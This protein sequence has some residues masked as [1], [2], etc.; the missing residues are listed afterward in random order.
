[1]ARL[2]PTDFRARTGRQTGQAKNGR[3]NSAEMGSAVNN[4]AFP[5]FGDLW[6]DLLR[7]WEDTGNSLG[8]DAMKSP[9]FSKF[10]N[11]A[12]SSSAALQHVFADLSAKYLA[13]LNL[14]TKS[15]ITAI[16]ERLHAIEKRIEEMQLTMAENQSQGPAS[17]GFVKPSRNRQPP[18]GD[19]DVAA[20]RAA[21]VG[22]LM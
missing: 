20:D 3:N 16:A 10:M 13:A 12:T 21:S 1:M 17:R 5:D 18:G 15:D 4:P 11:Q 2:H 9:E 7:Q 22:G 8:T 19:R 14:P 6:R